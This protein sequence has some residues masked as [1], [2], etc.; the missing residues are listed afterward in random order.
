MVFIY[1]DGIWPKTPHVDMYQFITHVNLSHIDTYTL[2]F[3]VETELTGQCG[4]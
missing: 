2:A 1:K 3:K 4:S